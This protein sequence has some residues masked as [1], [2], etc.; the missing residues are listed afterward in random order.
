MVP[1]YIDVAESLP[2]TPIGKIQKA[3]LRQL[4]VSATAWDR[5]R[6]G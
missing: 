3:V 1:R 2:K 5:Q 4:G 6:A